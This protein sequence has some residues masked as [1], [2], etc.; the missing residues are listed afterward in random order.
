MKIGTFARKFDLNIS[1]VRYYVQNGLLTPGKINGHY[2]FGKECVSDMQNIM[3]Y[4]KY[5]FSLEEIQLLFFME[6]ASGFQ[7]EIVLEICA[8]ILRKKRSQLMV[9]RDN[10]TEFIDDLEKEINGLALYRHPKEKEDGVPFSYIPFLSCAVCQKPLA[11]QS[12]SLTSGCINSGEL[13]CECGYQASIQEG[14]ILC[15]GYSEETPFKAFDNIESIISMKDQFSANYRMLIKKANIWMY[16]SLLNQPHETKQIMAGPFT[17]NFIF[18]YMEKLG[19]GNLY[20]LVDPSLNR[21]RKIKKYLDNRNYNV[22]YMVGTPENLPMRHK[23]VDIYIDDYSMVNSL[24]TYNKFYTDAIGSF[25]K[26]GGEITGI[27]TEYRSAPKSLQ[28]FK[29]LHPDFEPKGMTWNAL[30]IAW[31]KEGIMI[32]QEKNLGATTPGEKHFEQNVPGEQV[33]VQAYLAKKAVCRKK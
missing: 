3:K 16:N 26:E 13:S 21:I 9:E 15:P 18:E 20:I 11:I 19:P 31:T 7:D 25:I 27:F 22:V 29:T 23:S 28:N 5:Q 4:K 12:A 30:K 17:L 32:T 24:F 6:K 33:T 1:T 2:D 8:D 10:L 14:I